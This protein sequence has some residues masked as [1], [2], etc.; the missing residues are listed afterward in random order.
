M[1]RARVREGEGVFEL[2][3]VV[4]GGAGSSC[5]EDRGT[6]TGMPRGIEDARWTARS[7]SEEEVR[8]RRCFQ[9]NTELAAEP[10]EEKSCSKAAGD[11]LRRTTT[12]ASAVRGQRRPLR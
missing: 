4:G 12:V 10:E 3:E 7:L 11:A 9:A 1:H 8:A 5:V 2:G 6:L